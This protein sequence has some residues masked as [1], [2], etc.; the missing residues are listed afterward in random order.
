MFDALAKENRRVSLNDCLNKGT[1]LIEK[2]PS[3]LAHFRKEKIAVSGDIAK[4]F[5]Q[6]S[7][8]QED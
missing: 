3:C 2:I 5:L 1:N 6:I 8:C 7:V 4:A